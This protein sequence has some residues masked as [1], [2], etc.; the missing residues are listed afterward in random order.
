M[1]FFRITDIWYEKV[2]QRKGAKVRFEKW[3]LADK[4]WWAAKNSGA[5]AP[6]EERDFD[7]K[8]ESLQCPSCSVASPRIYNEG[9]MCLQTSCQKF[10]MING[11][12]APK[13]LSYHP[14]FL[15]YR[16]PPRPLR[17]QYSLVP[18]FLATL[19]DDDRDITYIRV[20][21]RGIVCP[22]CHKCISRKFWRGWRCSD[23]NSNSANGAGRCSFEKMLTMHPASLRSVVGDFEL[24]VEGIRAL[25]MPPN[26]MQPAFEDLGPYQKYTY[27]LPEVG[28]VTH[29]V[30]TKSVNSR[31]NGPNDLFRELQTIDIP[32]RRYPLQQSVGAYSCSA[33]CFLPK[34]TRATSSWN[35]DLTLR[36]Q[37]REFPAWC[38]DLVSVY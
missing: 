24:G 6:L 36:C 9:W 33:S 5:P 37:L 17:P 1:A 12:D 18:N 13:N 25:P 3:D 2:G 10:W 31:P 19:S 11:S 34:L 27:Q 23:L 8:P 35:L 20:A 4:S 32:L 21:W 38:L 26:C 29:F 7:T 22:E 16:T 15:Q 28:S 30:A 14:H